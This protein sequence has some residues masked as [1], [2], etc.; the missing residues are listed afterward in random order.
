VQSKALLGVAAI[1]S[2]DSLDLVAHAST[3]TVCLF[4]LF[5]R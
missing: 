5:P 1:I 2:L 3:S 4:L